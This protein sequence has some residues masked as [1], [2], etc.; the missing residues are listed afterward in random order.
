M[1]S[2]TRYAL[3]R[4]RLI[5]RPL[6]RP[7][8]R[9][10]AG[11]MFALLVAI[12]LLV[13]VLNVANSYVNNYFMTSLSLGEVGRFWRMIAVYGVVFGV[14]AILAAV[15]RFVEERLGIYLREALTRHLID[16][17]LADCHFHWLTRRED[18]DNP[19]QRIA[20]DVK[21]FTV[22]S[23]SFILI[24]LN[25]TIALVSFVGVLWKISPWAVGVAASYAAAGTV[26]TVFL[27]RPLVGLNFQQF[28][29]EADFRFRLI[30]VRE[31]GQS[32][33]LQGVEPWE[34]WRLN[35]R[36]Q[37]LVENFRRIIS[38]NLGLNAFVGAFNYGTL[39]LPVLIV[40]PLYFRHQVEFGAITQSVAAFGFVLN[41]FTVIVTQFQQITSLAAGA[42]RLGALVE[43]LDAPPPHAGPQVL[44][45]VTH[46]H[47]TFDHL[48][49]ITPDTSRALVKDLTL[50]VA[51]H[52]RLLV[53]GPNGAGK[54]A[55]LL[56]SAG[57]WD[58][59]QG[60]VI[61][62]KP[63]Q[64]MFL[65]QEPFL[66][67]STLRQQLL[68]GTGCRDLPDE[69]IHEVFREVK[70][71]RVLERVGGLDAAR[72]WP[73]VLSPGERR[74]FAFA[75]LIL[76]EPTFAFIDAGVSGVTDFWFRQLYGALHKTRTT[77]ISIGD[78]PALREYHDEVL[79]LDGEGNWMPETVEK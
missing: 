34:S 15:A 52:H 6:F 32:I 19:D 60:R 65:P 12:L 63:G 39:I 41:A 13:A 23:L 66:A 53:T 61:R 9:W 58:R 28:K 36:L 50:A 64:L 72:D 42:E 40:V 17:Y 44:L 24:L 59:G 11:G 30:H 79:D 51:P 78:H 43:V 1:L 16:R 26:G 10:R 56:A 21:T 49:L 48:T 35:G 2:T 70:F 18:I 62:P 77:Y 55:L 29:K 4:L 69:K 7:E 71:E 31:H 76:A 14:I 54:T 25:S 22:N 74:L 38:V 37:A 67:D 47:V 57:L 8:V 20:E 5:A 3:S 68:E 33:A 46:P 45:S 27:A 75:R 73:K